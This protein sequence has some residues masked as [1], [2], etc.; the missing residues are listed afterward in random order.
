MREGRETGKIIPNQ[1]NRMWGL[2]R[3]CGTI[4]ES[5]VESVL[6]YDGVRP[7]LEET[8][9]ILKLRTSMRANVLCACQKKD[10]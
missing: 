4:G 7:A 8:V 10:N 6:S 9:L 2:A 5:R 3:A 1:I